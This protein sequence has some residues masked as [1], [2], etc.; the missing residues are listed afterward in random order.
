MDIWNIFSY[1][2]MGAGVLFMLFGVIGLFR[3]KNFYLRAQVVSKIDT[4]GMPTLIFGLA[5]RHGL[6]FF[7]GKLL[8][9]VIIMLILNPLVTHILVRS[10]H[11]SGYELDASEGQ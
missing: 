11:I 10:A 7:T 1:I 2:I 9:I 8:L 5:L 4:V 6:S 3:F